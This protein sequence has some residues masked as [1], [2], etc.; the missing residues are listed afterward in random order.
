MT[1]QSKLNLLLLVAALLGLWWRRRG[2]AS[3]FLAWYLAYGAAARVCVLIW[4]A[5]TWA[6][7]F[8]TEV[9]CAF[10]A[11]AMAAEMLVLVFG[12][13]P[14]GRLRSSAIAAALLL[15]AWVTIM[16]WAPV[17]SAEVPHSDQ[18]WYQASQRMIQAKFT[19]GWLFMVV[20]ALALYYGVPLDPLHRDV[21]QG[22]STWIFIQI[23]PAAE[24]AVLDGVLHLGE[25]SFQRLIYTGMLLG[26]VRA[27]WR[28]DEL[29][30]LNSE[31]LR[32]LQPWRV[33]A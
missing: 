27:A 32:R 29:P 21:A 2:K 30:A 22:Y 13:L 20:V 9:P 26:W 23:I 10:L 31:A 14:L 4:P 12:G 33:H 28:E 11:L 25:A 5:R 8:C 18:I 19:A 17:Q 15:V 6:Y 7:V 24:L 16:A 3:R 1:L